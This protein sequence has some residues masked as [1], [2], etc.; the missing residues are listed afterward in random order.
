MNELTVDDSWRKLPRVRGVGIL[1]RSVILVTPLAALACTRAVTEHP[2]PVLDIV[3]VLLAVG[4]A[5]APDGPLGVLVIML[6]AIEWGASVHDRTTLWSVAV[7]AALALF[8]VCLAAATV[9][10]PGARWT[11]AMCRRWT[12]RAA[13]A[14]G[15]GVATWAVLVAIDGYEMPSSA[16]LVAAS[17]LVLALGGVWVRDGHP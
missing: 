12:R 6:V 1:L 5:V 9:S 17:L 10:P 4:C 2:L 15:S 8:H 13:V 7:A 3:I 16:I 14:M 11:S